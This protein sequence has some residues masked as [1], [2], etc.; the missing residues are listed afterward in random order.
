MNVNEIPSELYQKIQLRFESDRNVRLLRTAQ[1]DAQRMGDFKKALRIA[2]DVENLW[3]ICLENYIQKAE[4]E[5]G[6]IDTESA[7]IPREDKDE[8]MEKI[9]VLFMCCDIIESSILDLNDV[10]H[11]THSDI[12][13]TTFN[14]LHQALDLA[15]QKLQYLQKTGDYMKDLVWADSCDKMYD[16]MQSKAKRIIRKRKES[17][18]WGE[19]LK[20]IEEGPKES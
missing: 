14:D 11:R 18:N 4:R 13:I 6:T 8:M 17:N 10:L 7:D 19:N 9:M 2:K 5:V 20:R 15:K 3:T 12:N 1:Q 16:M